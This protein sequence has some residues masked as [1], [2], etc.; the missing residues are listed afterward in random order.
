[1]PDKRVPACV[2]CHGP[3]GTRRNPHY[4]RLAGQYADYILLQLTLF[5]AQTRGGTPYHHIV[6]RVASQLT[7]EDM[8]A[9]AAF[10]A[11]LPAT[12]EPRP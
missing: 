2:T 6:E 3:G 12:A 9:V 4:P 7:D 8:R 1:M 10:F 5:K 11:S